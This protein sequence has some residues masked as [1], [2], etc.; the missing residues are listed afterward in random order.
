M[1]KTVPSPEVL[2]LI[3]F[4]MSK[5]F[6][7]LSNVMWTFFEPMNYYKGFKKPKMNKPGAVDKRKHA[8]QMIPQKLEKGGLKVAKIAV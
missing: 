7:I 8:V 1:R 3:T 5:D 2:A 4:S 6:M